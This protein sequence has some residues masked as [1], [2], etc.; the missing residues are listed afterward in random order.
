[1]Q[2]QMQDQ[3]YLGSGKLLIREFGARAPFEEVGNCSAVTLSPQTNTIALADSTA[4]GGGE[5]NRVDRLTGVEFAYT[6]HDFAPENFARA[7]RGT[8]SK[9]AAGKAMDEPITA[10]KG[11]FTPLG[12]IA[13]AV[14]AVK[15]DTGT[16]VL[17]AGKD[18]IFQDGGLY[19]PEDS[20]IPPSTDGKPNI[21]VSY[22]YGAQ[23]T[24][25][26]L[27]N[28]AKQ[29]EMLFLGLNEAQSGKAVRIR[30][31]KVSG[32]VM[33]QLGLIGDQH[34]QGE[35]TGALLPDTSKG[36]QLSKYF[37]VD[38]EVVG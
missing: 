22:D 33:A 10:Y 30:V 3:S 13:T 12:K 11:G 9:V 35:V 14:T 20:T 7:L 16:A 5:R 27:V 26:A 21:K 37:V 4:P 6:F 32:G 19:I 1:M 31:H 2:G 8:S 17:E 18:Y 29:Y 23:T 28:P 24:V 34:G 36:A 38:Q 15:P 25:Q